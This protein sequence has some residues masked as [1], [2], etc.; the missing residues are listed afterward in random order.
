ML[1]RLVHSRLA[2]AAVIVPLVLLF[3]AF[4][5]FQA[6]FVDCASKSCIPAKGLFKADSL[7]VDTTTGALDLVPAATPNTAGEATAAAVRARNEAARLRALRSAAKRHSGR[8]VWG[9][10]VSVGFLLSLAA[11]G[12][13]GLLLTRTPEEET[14]PYGIFL[15]IVFV[16]A[17]AV[18]IMMWLNPEGHMSMIWGA[19][20]STVV[21]GTLGE[22]RAAGVM[23]L[24]N[25]VGMS[26]ALATIIAC[27]LLLVGPRMQPASPP[28]EPAGQD[29]ADRLR[30]RL[31]PITH[32]LRHLRI[33]LYLATV[34]LVVGVLRMQAVMNWVLAFVTAEDAEALAEL[35]G[36]VPS[37]VGAFYSLVLAAVYLPTAYI[38]RARA[39]KV[40][41]DAEAPPEV[42]AEAR[43]T[44]VLSH[45]LDTTLPRIA[46]LLGPLL[47]GPFASLLERL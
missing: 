24:A 36:T 39:E 14:P 5:G 7:K 16:P 30:H 4:Y 33:F 43:G 9:F 26:S 46:A 10:F 40:I 34:L 3:A 38:L 21:S 31:A 25:S 20:N 28:G 44:T 13:A 37:V 45:S 23:N 19:L 32:R 35:L 18:G 22:P 11:F 17:A 41:T 1:S 12:V 8:Y 47:A 29:A 2:I 27:T 6:G 15:A 42:K